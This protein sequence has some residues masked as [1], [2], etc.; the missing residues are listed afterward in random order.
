MTL[1]IQN[2][3]QKR[4]VRGKTD[5]PEPIIEKMEEGSNSNNSNAGDGDINTNNVDGS[6]ESTESTAESGDSKD[7]TLITKIKRISD[8]KRVTPVTTTPQNL[9]TTIPT[10][11]MSSR[12]EERDFWSSLKAANSDLKYEPVGLAG[13]AVS[14]NREANLNRFGMPISVIDT[15]SIYSAVPHRSPRLLSTDESVKTV[16]STS[17]SSGSRY[18]RKRLGVNRNESDSPIPINERIL[19]PP[20][21]IRN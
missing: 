5:S 3:L 15:K 17:A 4:T 20:E 7:K 1:I 9:T 6:R 10:H 21:F 8:A 16:T 19:I 14:G 13:S 11:D 2:I 18:S 12:R